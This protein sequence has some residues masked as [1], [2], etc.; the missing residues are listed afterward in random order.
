METGQGLKLCRRVEV[1]AVRSALRRGLAANFLMQCALWSKVMVGLLEE[2]KQACCKSIKV[3]SRAL[4]DVG[5]SACL[6]LLVLDKKGKTE[7]EQ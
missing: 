5:P 1:L 3:L 2:D 4:P 7:E 6:A